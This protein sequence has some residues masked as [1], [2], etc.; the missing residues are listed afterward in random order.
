MLLKYYAVIKSDSGGYFVQFHDIDNC[1][2]DGNTLSEAVHMAEDVLLAMYPQS[3]LAAL[4]EPSKAADIQLND[5]ESLV[6]IKVDTEKDE[7]V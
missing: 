1:Y 5:G 6:Y 4:P 7:A 3:Y 2:T